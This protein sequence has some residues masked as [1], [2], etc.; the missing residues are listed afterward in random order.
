M[1]DMPRLTSLMAVDCYKAE[2]LPTKCMPAHEHS[3]ED[4]L[5]LLA[6]IAHGSWTAAQK[7]QL[8]YHLE[9]ERGQLRMPLLR[10]PTARTFLLELN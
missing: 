4:S 10:T 6:I 2:A 5:R 7:L 3:G 8:A 1:S 9:R